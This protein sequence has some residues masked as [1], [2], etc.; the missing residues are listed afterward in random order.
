MEV[1]IQLVVAA[2]VVIIAALAGPA[3]AST[4][5]TEVRLVGSNTMQGAG[6]T[7]GIIVGDSMTS[8]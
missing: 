8:N 1:R 6:I 3:S 7:D 4:I 2:A 5:V